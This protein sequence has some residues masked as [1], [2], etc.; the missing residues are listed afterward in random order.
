V[1]RWRNALCLWRSARRA[2]LAGEIDVNEWCRCLDDARLLL[3]K[4]PFWTLGADL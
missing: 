3:G 2:F 4:P 1:T